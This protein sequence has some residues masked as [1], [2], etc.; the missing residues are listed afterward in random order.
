MAK[1]HH[2]V[3]IKFSISDLKAISSRLRNSGFRVKTKRTHE[4]NVLFDTVN[5]AFRK[6]GEVFRVRK[7]G[8]S[9][10]LTHK[11]KAHDGR[12]KQRAETEIEIREGDALVRMLDAIG[13]A[14]SFRYEK[15]RTEWT[16]GRGV[17]VIDETPVGNFGEIEG[18]PRWI[19]TTAKKLGLAPKQYSTK[20]YAQVFFDW[21]RRTRSRAQNMTWK[22]IGKHL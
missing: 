17:V 22:D 6:S 8:R 18:A 19:D 20:S 14:E 21:K 16:D 7:Y 1:S 11:A 9:W 15:F 5:A 13:L 4:M 12:H 3:E 10:T 2:E